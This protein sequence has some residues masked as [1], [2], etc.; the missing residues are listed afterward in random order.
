MVAKALKDIELVSSL[1][2][3]H[4]CVDSI[5]VTHWRISSGDG[6]YTLVLFLD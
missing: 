3:K 5:T 6:C 1:D 2:R 4:A